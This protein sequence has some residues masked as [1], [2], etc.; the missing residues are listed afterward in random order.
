M[1][2]KISLSVTL[3]SDSKRNNTGL[4]C[5]MLKKRDLHAK[6][7]EFLNSIG[8]IPFG[9]DDERQKFVIPKSKVD[10]IKHEFF[11]HAPE[12]WAPS[13]EDRRYIKQASLSAAKPKRFQFKETLQN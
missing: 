13:K 12:F 5:F 3:P 4:I 10:A 2:I 9:L 1:K 6:T 8:A 7:K 11:G